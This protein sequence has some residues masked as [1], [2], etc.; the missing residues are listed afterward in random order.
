MPTST[1][2][3]E[4]LNDDERSSDG[5]RKN[6]DRRKSHMDLPKKTGGLARTVARGWE[7]AKRPI[8]APKF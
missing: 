4:N 6:T 7:G 3:F 5:R 2:E 8:G 1:N